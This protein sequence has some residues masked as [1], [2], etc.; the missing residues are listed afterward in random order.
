MLL[1][2]NCSAPLFTAPR[3][4]VLGCV[5]GLTNTK[6]NLAHLAQR[7]VRHKVPRPAA[8]Q[9]L[10]PAVRPGLHSPHG[11]LGPLWTA[12]PAAAAPGRQTADG[13]QPPAVQRS[14]SIS[15]AF[16]PFEF[17]TLCSASVMHT[18]CA[19]MVGL[20]HDGQQH[21]LLQLQASKE[22]MVGNH[23]QRAMVGWDESNVWCGG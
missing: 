19:P 17:C 6:H 15:C 13:W 21:L 16:M 22:L 9:L 2:S 23:L 10:C 1:D 7:A 11:R 5:F 20:V 18:D 14:S 4:L 3:S 8:T 12:A